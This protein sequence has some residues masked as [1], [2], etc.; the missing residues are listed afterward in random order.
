M[1]PGALFTLFERERGRRY[2][3]GNRAAQRRGISA[4]YY[5]YLA[6]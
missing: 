3:G 2:V 6:T 4:R 5:T 1:L